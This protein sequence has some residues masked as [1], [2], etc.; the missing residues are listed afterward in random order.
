MVFTS[1]K[2]ITINQEDDKRAKQ[3]KLRQNEKV[4]Y[5]H[6]VGINLGKIQNLK[7]NVTQKKTDIGIPKN[8][9]V[10]LSVGELIKQK[11]HET[12][13]KALNQIKDKNFIYLICGRDVLLEYLQN[14]TKQLWIEP[15]V[16]FLGF[17]KYI[18]EI[19]KTADLFISH[20]T[21][22]DY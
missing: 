22:K 8:T 1:F 4:Y 19:C 10:L 5:V 17:R 3:F 12:V 20:P 14:L 21:K 15:K 11:K 16:K 18:A 9:P 2:L 6:D 7:V 13:L